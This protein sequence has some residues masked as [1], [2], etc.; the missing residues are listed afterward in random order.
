MYTLP[1]CLFSTRYHDRPQVRSGINVTTPW[2]SIYTVR[3]LHSLH[4]WYNGTIIPLY[5]YIAM[6]SRGNLIWRYYY[7]TSL[8]APQHQMVDDWL[9]SLLSLAYFS[10]DKSP[11]VCAYQQVCDRSSRQI[12]NTRCCR[13][14][15]FWHIFCDIS[16]CNDLQTHMY[17]Y[18]QVC[19]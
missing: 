6:A 11:D 9:K 7:V 8:N 18:I 2:Q 14:L 1:R 10:N 4:D 13:H 17:T 16:K 5:I 15:E 12:S 3:T 19:I